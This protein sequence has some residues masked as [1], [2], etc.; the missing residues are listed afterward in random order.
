MWFLGK[1][2][3]FCGEIITFGWWKITQCMW[4]N[5]SQKSRQGSD[6]PPFR[7]CLHFGTFWTGNPSLNGL[8]Y[9]I[10]MLRE[11]CRNQAHLRQ[12]VK[13]QT[14]YE[15]F[16]GALPLLFC[17]IIFWLWELASD[18]LLLIFNSSVS[19]IIACSPHPLPAAG[20]SWCCPRPR[21]KFQR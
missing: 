21:C 1:K 7:Q 5:P 10:V 13:D 15:F 19:S 6:P 14:F 12:L 4:T 16:F 18:F 9:V 8:A 3:H 20:R 11:G 17:E 2:G